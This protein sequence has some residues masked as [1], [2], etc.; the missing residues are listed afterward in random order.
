MQLGLFGRD[1]FSTRRAA[2]RKPEQGVHVGPEASSAG[3]GPASELHRTL[4]PCRTRPRTCGR[5]PISVQAHRRAPIPRFGRKTPEAAVEV[6]DPRCPRP[7][8]RRA[9]ARANAVGNRA[10]E[11]R[12]ETNHRCRRTSRPS[13]TRGAGGGDRVWWGR[14]VVPSRATRQSAH[15]C[16]RGLR[17]RRSAPRRPRPAAPPR[18]SMR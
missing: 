11:R 4:R 8:S 10:G 1:A 7:R 14:T 12:G 17:V 5:A 13:R 15:S 6:G 9:A 18:R 2:A 16:A 3:A